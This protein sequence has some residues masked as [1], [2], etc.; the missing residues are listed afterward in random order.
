MQEGEGG[1]IRRGEGQRGRDGKREKEVK[2][3]KVWR[4]E[5]DERGRR[6]R[7][8]KERRGRWE[9]GQM[10]ACAQTQPCVLPWCRLSQSC[11]VA[12]LLS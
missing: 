12:L 4:K 3:P 10:G 11:T 9:G 1:G 5:R 6:K 7:N 8:K 2:K